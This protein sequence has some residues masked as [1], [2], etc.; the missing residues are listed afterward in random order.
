MNE[1][2][3]AFL[4]CEGFEKSELLKTK[5]LLKE[6][7]KDVDVLSAEEDNL[8]LRSWESGDWSEK[9]EAEK[10]L[11]DVLPEDYDVLVIPGGVINA[12]RLRQVEPA[13]QLIMDF[14]ADGKIVAAI[15]HGPQLLVEVDAL[16]GLK[17]TSAKAIKKDLENAGATFID[18][19]VVC[20]KGIITSRKP[21]DIPTF[22]AKIIEEVNEGE[23]YRIYK[24]TA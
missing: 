12:D 5:E 14:I 24:K 21:D 17:A 23:H 13:R 22:A 18:D 20:E 2:R 3:I 15:C 11:T 16:R 4:C 7:A 19:P 8:T 1:A 6:Q 10:L 9:I